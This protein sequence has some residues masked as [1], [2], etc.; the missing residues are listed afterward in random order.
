MNHFMNGFSDEMEKVALSPEYI[1]A[2]ARK[3]IRENPSRMKT[4]LRRSKLRGE[5]RHSKSRAALLRG[6]DEGMKDAKRR[7][8][9]ILGGSG[10]AAGGVAMA[11]RDKE[12]NLREPKATVRDLREKTA[13]FPQH[14]IPAATYDTAKPA[15]ATMNAS[16]GAQAKPGA[17]PVTT[18]PAPYKPAPTPMTAV[19]QNVA[20]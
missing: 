16:Q 4:L 6:A 15:R 7:A 1:R 19:N 3:A 8:W 10:L 14:E 11:L 18:A 2:A 13:A 12:P 5:G 20:E 17:L 9:M